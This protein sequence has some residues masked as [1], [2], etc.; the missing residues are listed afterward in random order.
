MA[1]QKESSIYDSF[2]LGRFGDYAENASNAMHELTGWQM[3]AAHSFYDQSMRAAQA[4][5]DFAQSQIQ[6]GARLSKEILKMGM[7]SSDDIT[8][9]FDDLSGRYI[10]TSKQ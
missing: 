3:R 7:Q 10:K 6:E 5:A 8:K 4:W 2:A 1:T 9:S